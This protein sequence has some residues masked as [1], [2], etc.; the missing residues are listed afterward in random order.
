M[1]I[2]VLDG[3]TENPGD[4]SW[5]RLEELGEFIVYD[6]SS[7]TVRM[8]RSRVSERQK[9]SLP[10]K[11]PSQRGYWTAARPSLYRRT[12]YRLQM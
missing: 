5:G 8:R 1:K 10:I 3:Y 7:L 4:L 9:S 2:V 6:R 11:R 12:G